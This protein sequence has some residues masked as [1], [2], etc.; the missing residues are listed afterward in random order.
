MVTYVGATVTGYTGGTS[1]SKALPSPAGTAAGDT[2]YVVLRLESA[3]A[4][5]LTLPSGWELKASLGN[6]VDSSAYLLYKHAVAG[7]VGATHTFTWTGGTWSTGA[8]STYRDGAASG[9]PFGGDTGWHAFSGSTI[10]SRT[11]TST[12][13]GVVLGFFTAFTDTQTVTAPSGYV[14][15]YSTGYASINYL[16][17]STAA[18]SGSI[19]TGA[20]SWTA[21]GQ[22]FVFYGT[23]LDAAA[24]NVAP[25]AD[26]GADLADLE[27]WV[28]FTL[29]G[30]ASTDP[31]GTI[32]SVLWEHTAGAG[33]ATIADPTALVTT[34][35]IAPDTF[36]EVA[37]TFR[38]TVTDNDGATDTDTTTR[39]VLEAAAA[40]YADA[41]VWK[42]LSVQA[43]SGG[44]WQPIRPVPLTGDQA[45]DLHS[46]TPDGM[47]QHIGSGDP[48]TAAIAEGPFSGWTGD[49]HPDP[50]AIISGYVTAAA[51]SPFVAALY[52]IPNRDAG[53]YSGG[54]FANRGEYLTWVT[55]AR[56]GAGSAPLWWV[57]EPDALGHAHNFTAGDAAERQ[58]TIRQAVVLLT[59]NANARIYIDA[60]HWVPAA[61]MA[62]LLV[63]AGIADADGISCNVSNFEDADLMAAW[64][65]QVVEALDTTHGIGGKQ[66]VVDT[67]RSGNGGLPVGYPG[68]DIWHSASRTWCNPPGRGVGPRPRI[69][70]AWPR[71]DAYLW[72][73]K[74]GES[75]GDFPT[76][77]Q[78]TIFSTDAPPAGTHWPEWFADF[79]A[80]SDAAD[81]DDLPGGSPPSAPTSV[82]MTAITDDT[83]T[84]NWGAPTDTGSTPLTQYVVAWG[85]WEGPKPT[86]EFSYDLTGFDPETQYT[87]SVYAENSDGRSPAATVTFTTAA[88]PVS[89]LPAKIAAGYYGKWRSER[90]TT[91]PHGTASGYNMFYL[92]FAT[93]SQGVSGDGSVTYTHNV[94]SNAEMKADIAAIRAAGVPV[95]LAVGGATDYTH[96]HTTARRDAFYASIQTIYDNIGPLDGLDWNFETNYGT[97]SSYSVYDPANGSP[98]MNNIIWISQQ[99][100]ALYGAGFAITKPPTPG[101]EFGHDAGWMQAMHDAGVIDL[102][103]PQ[104]YDGGQNEVWPGVLQKWVDIIGEAGVG[105]GVVTSSGYTNAGVSNEATGSQAVV[106]SDWSAAKSAY[107]G[108]RG[109]FYW[110]TGIDSLDSPSYWFANT[111]SQTLRA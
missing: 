88:A 62:A 107:P 37:H 97:W 5:S 20:G 89:P 68:A 108:L 55:S 111:F 91:V 30:S 17:R 70:V 96:I 4:K 14:K 43:A 23:M 87:I 48:L 77:A 47:V 34:A 38:L 11:Y 27:P 9:D 2:L 54:G 24:A 56:D 33:T 41:G 72:L 93:G 7:D 19:S 28:D 3:T 66:F 90:L 22:A 81:L 18:G 110:H 31:D 64:A 61:D 104:I 85:G 101:D 106:A 21:T 100:K 73:K 39:T 69:P 71:C 67:S 42:P 65:T 29:D 51:G 84:V 8:I 95:L 10:P 105:Y 1:V 26:A 78:Q 32:A 94:H 15:D 109:C 79:V 6:G 59:A 45:L 80:N 75:D 102:I 36:A 50:G 74:T 58:E 83:A 82:T 76:A 92:A 57:V 13:A 35:S 46:I 44:V 86:S 40:G 60:S 16:R 53:G 99:L 63:P 25:T 12:G 52:A 98:A 49:W 103:M